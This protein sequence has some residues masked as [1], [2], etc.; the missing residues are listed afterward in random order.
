[1][2]PVIAAAVGGLHGGRHDR[3]LHQQHCRSGQRG[4]EVRSGGRNGS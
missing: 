4:R 1:M 3:G 2:Q